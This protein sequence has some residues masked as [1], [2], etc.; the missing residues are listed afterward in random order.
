M[1]KL[2]EVKSDCRHFISQVPCGPNKKFGAV[3]NECGYYEKTDGK[4]LIIKL[5][6]AGD[7]VRTTPLL[8]PLKKDYPSAKIFWLTYYPTLV[9]LRTSPS[10]DRA[11][12]YDLQSISYLSSLKFD[13]VINLDKDIEAISL[14]D[15]ISADRKDG[16]TLKDG[17][18]Y[19]VNEKAEEKFITGLFDSVSKM[20]KKSYPEEI[21]E[22][23]GYEFNKEKYLIDIKSEADIFQNEKYGL[24]NGKIKIGLNTGCG[25]RWVSRLWKDEYWTE[26][27][28]KL[29]SEGYQVILLGGKQEDE[30]NKFLSGN[31]GADYFGYFELDEYINLMNKCDIIVTQVTMSMHLAI[32]LGKKLVLMNNI[33]NKNEFELYGNGVI[34]EPEKECKCYF[35][36]VCTNKEYNCI[37]YLTPEKVFEEIVNS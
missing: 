4:I 20:N 2:S 5:G 31:T 35:Q 33:F 11:F 23:C 17:N 25:A 8:Y 14:M 13:Y 15:K 30:K 3:C 34:V 22:I 32:A 27:I 26:L 21:F 1:I 7:V 37:D 29:L 24:N 36:P 19:P 6:A 16:F 12:A 9:P 28:N 10:A 18:C